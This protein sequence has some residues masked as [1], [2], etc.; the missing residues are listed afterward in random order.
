L[1]KA[2]TGARCASEKQVPRC[3]RNDRQ[4]GKGKGK[5]KSKGKGKG[6]G[7][8]KS[9]SKSKSKSKGKGKGEYR[10]LSAARYALRSR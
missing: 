4:K 1:S 5:G 6:K 2:R 10:G 8:G 9:K 3:A 7:K